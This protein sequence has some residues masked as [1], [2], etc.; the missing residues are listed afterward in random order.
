MAFKS[1]F[2]FRVAAATTFWIFIMAS[3]FGIKHHFLVVKC[4]ITCYKALDSRDGDFSSETTVLSVLFAL[5]LGL[6]E[7]FIQPPP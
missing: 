4:L 6:G 2:W 1:T 5:C 7:S 3:V